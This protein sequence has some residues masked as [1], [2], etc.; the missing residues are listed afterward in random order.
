MRSAWRYV[1]GI[2]GS[3]QLL[4]RWRLALCFF[5]FGLICVGILRAILVLKT[6]FLFDNWRKDA[7]KYWNNHI[8]YTELNE[9]DD[10]SSESEG[11]AL[12]FGFISGISCIVGML[13][14]GF[15]LFSS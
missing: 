12:I 3:N 15:S 6:R 7:K 11:L 8:G 14:G 4:N 1:D 2:N 5:A 10:K 13:I 9:K